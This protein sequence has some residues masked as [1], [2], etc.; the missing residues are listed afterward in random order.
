MPI[1]L[2]AS[3]PTG[4]HHFGSENDH[5]HAKPRYTPRPIF[6]HICMFLDMKEWSRGKTGPHGAIALAETIPM[7][8][9]TSP[10]LKN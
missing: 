10:Y 8:Y 4:I 9:W 7:S 6:G 2:F 3:F 1:H 5:F